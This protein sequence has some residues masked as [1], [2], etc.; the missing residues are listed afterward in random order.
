MIFGQFMPI[1]KSVPISSLLILLIGLQLFLVF[2][3]EF[4]GL[5]SVSGV[6]AS[7]KKMGFTIEFPTKFFDFV[8]LKPF[9]LFC[10][11][12]LHYIIVYRGKHK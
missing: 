1:K 3:L 12:L 2:P 8:A 6:K 4:V 7:N 9:N 5:K 11:I 10:I